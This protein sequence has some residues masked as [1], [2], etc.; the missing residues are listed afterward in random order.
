MHRREKGCRSRSRRSPHGQTFTPP[1]WR[2]DPPRFGG[3]S[4]Q[5]A[6]PP[7]S[8]RWRHRHQ[9]G[10]VRPAGSPTCESASSDSEPPSRDVDDSNRGS[11]KWAVDVPRVHRPP[12]IRWHPPGSRCRGS[13]GT[14][15]GPPRPRRRRDHRTHAAGATWSDSTSREDGSPRP[16]RGRGRRE[17]L[18][19]RV[20]P[21]RED[22]PQPSRI[23]RH[24][25]GGPSAREGRTQRP[26]ASHRRWWVDH[27]GSSSPG[28][29]PGWLRNATGGLRPGRISL[30]T[31]WHDPSRDTDLREKHDVVPELSTRPRRQ[32]CLTRPAPPQGSHT[33]A[34]HRQDLF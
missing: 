25:S 12:S 24:P 10:D 34:N 33:A 9:A 2:R 22:P 5:A 28:W 21:R 11:G 14:P 32:P 17:H 7:I 19:R 18:R 31:M 30:R 27:P 13:G 29:I 16:V 4:R 20:P 15:A 23:D 3:P 1:P 6:D 26:R 8:G